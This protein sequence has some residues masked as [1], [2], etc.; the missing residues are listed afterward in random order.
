MFSLGVL[1]IVAKIPI[2]I[3]ARLFQTKTEAKKFARNILARSDDGEII[4]G[5]DD[6]FLRDLVALH[7]EAATKIGCGI[8]HF[9]AQRDPVWGNTRH[10]LIVRTDGSSTDVSF[11]TCIDGSN[12]RRDVFHALRHAV[13]DQVVSF[14]QAAFASDVL[15]ICPYTGEILTIS[16]AHVDH[17]PPDTFFALATHWMQHKGLKL[18]NISLVD[19]TDN[20]WVC[21]MCD[22]S[23]EKS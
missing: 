13:A 7:H 21:A 3:G 12:A 15:P 9:T 18:S 19:S 5:L 17:T 22:F 11:H 8:A 4:T 1:R 14:Q 10:F 2:Q 20:Q 23:Q 16:D 6:L